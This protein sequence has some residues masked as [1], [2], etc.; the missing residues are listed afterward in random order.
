MYSLT[1]TF[2]KLL[3]KICFKCP[4][5]KF[6]NLKIVNL[7]LFSIV[8]IYFALKKIQIKLPNSSIFVRDKNASES[9]SLFVR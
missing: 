7:F 2:Q 9:R 3:S 8:H 1:N 4:K 6:V 5:I